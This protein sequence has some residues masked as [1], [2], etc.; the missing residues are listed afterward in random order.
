MGPERGNQSEIREDY[1]GGRAERMGSLLSSRNMPY[2][3]SEAELL[4]ESKAG[5]V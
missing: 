3:L 5:G 2:S 1:A 4:V